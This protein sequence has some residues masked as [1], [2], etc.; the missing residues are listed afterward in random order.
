MQSLIENSQSVLVDVGFA[1]FLDR[2]RNNTERFFI[3]ISD[4]GI[5]PEVVINKEKLPLFLSGKINYFLAII[6]TF[7]TYKKRNIFVQAKEFTWQGRVFNYVIANAKYFG[8]SIGIA[9]HAILS[10]G[11]FAITQL[12]N[13]RLIDYLR[14]IGKVKKCQKIIHPK[15][16]Y[17]DSQ[18]LFIEGTTNEP[19]T[20]DMDGEFVGYAPIKLTCLQQ[21]IRFLGEI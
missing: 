10:D 12:G 19:I 7:L 18:E 20:I 15:I 13:I 5:G 6:F 14:N 3:N 21:K 17:T 9:P 16:F 11:K 4:V 1:Q 8:N 2:K